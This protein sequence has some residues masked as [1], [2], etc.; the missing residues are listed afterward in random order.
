MHNRISTP[1]NDRSNNSG[2]LY[3]LSF[4]I[5]EAAKRLLFFMYFFLKREKTVDKTINKVYAVRTVRKQK[6]PGINTGGKQHENHYNDS[7]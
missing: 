4:F 1:K 6:Q 2:F 7:D 5:P 3:S